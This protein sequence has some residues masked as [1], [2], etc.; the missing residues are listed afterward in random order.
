[1]PRFH[2]IRVFVLLYALNASPADAQ[3]AS[4]DWAHGEITATGTGSPPAGDLTASQKRTMAIRA[5]RVDAQRQLLETVKGVQIDAAT[6]VVNAMADDRVN[7]AVRGL[8]RGAKQVGETTFLDDGTA[9]VTLALTIRG[10]LS[11][12]VLPVGRPGTE[13]I[14][15]ETPVE[16]VTYTGLVV[17]ARDRQVRPALAPR[18]IDEDDNVIFGAS[19]VDRAVAVKDGMAA[20]TSSTDT[21]F[22]SARAGVRRLIVRCL[23]STGRNRTNLV[24]TDDD[25]ERIKNA[26]TGIDFLAQCRVVILTD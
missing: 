23:R 20:Y 3:N 10:D 4:I 9:Q 16:N 18:I 17:D 22:V 1:M 19:I 14:Q 25:G 12:V 8:L 7:T 15:P 2:S 13:P 26:N 21:A 6:S 24:I 11:E 5:A